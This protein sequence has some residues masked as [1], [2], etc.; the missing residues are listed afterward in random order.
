MSRLRILLALALLPLAVVSSGGAA[1]AAGE[2]AG[3]TVF[4]FGEAAYHGSPPGPAL[5]QPLV[6]ISPTP[7]SEGYR[8]AAA[9][10]AVFAYGDAAYLGRAP[11]DQP[12]VGLATTASG[13]GYWLATVDGAVYPFGDAPRLGGM[14]GRALNRPIVGIA[15]TPSG[16]GYWLVASDGGLFSFGDAGFLGSTGSIA[17]NEPIVGMASTPSGRGYWLVASDGG[18]FSFGDA[19]FFGSTGSIRLNQPVVGMAATKSG[20]GYWLVASDGGLFAFGDAGFFGSL[21]GKPPDDGF[22]VGMAP[23][24]G[25]AGYW[26]A[27]SRIGD[28]VSVWQT[29]GLAPG[30]LG[31]AVDAARRSGGRAAVHHAG[32]VGLFA[33]RRGGHGVQ[34]LPPGWRVPMAAVAVD[35]AAAGPLL[36]GPVAVTLRRG[37]VVFGRESARLRGARVGDVVT[38]AGWDGR[39]HTRRVGL[40]APSSMVGSAELV[41]AERDAAAFGFS[42][43]ASVTIWGFRSRAAVDAELAR[44][45]P[46]GQIGIDRSWLPPRPD[47]TLPILR[48]KLAFGEFAY[49]PSGG[50]PVTLSPGWVAGNIGSVRLPILGTM[51]CNRHIAGALAGALQEVADR[52]LAG[53]IDVGDSR[54][55]GGC[56]N[57]RLIRGGD[58]GGN[59][60]RHSWG[61]AVD[62]NP[63]QNVF[64]GRVRMDHRVVEIFRRWGFAWGG[65]WPRADGMHFEW[66]PPELYDVG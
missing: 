45:I 35:P 14:R 63:S 52:G 26:L 19:R 3:S 55:N 12:V 46:P 5:G 11:G 2:P 65:T 66:A 16:R 31:G 33:V 25:G 61:I 51:T 21:G 44:S 39:A 20:R 10:G 18:L 50:D 1:G 64:G 34:V 41:F 15:S 58:S 40:I 54:R 27:A 6:A 47:R 38:L 29:G 48:L 43:P 60:S 62:I 9:D 36:G 42:R 59:L 49:L 53:A 56:W 30:T 57:A 17:L 13:A 32:T 23:T 37:E 8:L 4:G 7:S 24:P 22:V 28:S